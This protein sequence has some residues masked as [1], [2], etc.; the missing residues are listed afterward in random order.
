[1]IY[2][3]L[4]LFGCV[5]CGIILWS[6]NKSKSDEN[7]L[8]Q[9]LP[10][11]ETGIEFT[12]V[13]P[14]ND[15]INLFNYHYLF[16][17]NGVGIGDINNDGLNDVFFSANTG[18][19]KLYLN[20]GDFK[21]EDITEKAGVTTKQWMTGVSM[22]DVNNDGYI[23][24]YVC[25]SGPSKNK[26]DKRNKLFINNKNSTFTE[27]ASKW[28]VDDAGNASCASFFDF[29]N[30]GDLDMYLGNHAEKYFSD[31]NIPFTKQLKM[32]EHSQQHFYRNDGQF[33]TDITES[34]G[35]LAMGYCLSATPSDFNNDGLIDIYVCNDYHI[36]DYYYINNGDGTF[37]DK[38]YSSFKHTSNNSMGSDA[39]DVNNDGFTDLITLDM[40]PESPERFMTLL[41]PRDYDFIN[42]SNRNNYGNQY[43]KNV[44]NINVGNGMFSDQS[45]L[46]GVAR[47]DWSWSPLFCDFN[48]D[49]YQDLFVTN[50]Y[51][52]DVTNLDFVLFKNRREQQNG[53]KVTHKDV[54]DRL[55][56]EKLTN[57]LYINQQGNG[58]SNKSESFGTPEKTLSTGSAYGD[59]DG[60]GQ[61]DLIVCNQG[62][63]ALVYKNVNKSGNFINIKFTSKTNKT[64]IGTKV[65]VEQEAVKRMF[66]LSNNRGYLSSS[67]PIIHIGFGENKDNIKLS[68]VTL[69]G[70]TKELK[71]FEFNRTISI[72]IDEIAGANGKSVIAGLNSKESF[73]E[74]VESLKFKHSEQETPDFKREPLLP[75][76][77]TMLGPGMTT[78]DVNGDGLL[79][80]FMANASG[81]TGSK[82]MLQQN[83]GAFVDAKTQPWTNIKTDVTGCLLF[84]ADGDGDLDLYVATGGSE[85]SW[86]NANYTH[87]LFKNDGKGNFIDN[88]QNLPKVTGSSSSVAAGD[89][90]NDGDLDLFVSGR[91]LPGLYPFIEI[92]S[93]LLRNEE[94][95]FV[96]ATEKD[97]PD[98]FM[99]GM[100][101][102]S[103]FTDY[104]NDGY[105][106]LMLVGEYTPIVFMKN[107]KGK[108]VN[109]TNEV[110]T[111]NYSGW[112]NSIAPIDIDND[113]DLDY[114]ISNKG[115]NSFVRAS[116][117]EPLN[118]YWSD[119]DGNGRHDF[120]F[121]YSKNEKEY[122]LY[123]MDEMVVAFPSFLSKKF[124]TYTAFGGKTMTE[125]FGEPNLSQNKMFANEFSHLLLT[126][127]GNGFAVSKLPFE[128]NIGPITGMMTID[129]NGDGFDD[130]VG[131]GN[132][133]YSRVTHG[134]DDALNGFVLLNNNGKLSF[135]NGPHVG[136]NVPGDGRAIVSL[137]VN[138]SI[139]I[140]ASQ[141]N[142]S[143]KTFKLK[144]NTTFIKAPKGAVKSILT[145]T[146]GKTK[147]CYIGYGGG[148]LS[149]RYPGVYLNKS[150]KSVQFYNSKGQ[151]LK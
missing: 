36:P 81:S 149:G 27:S 65:I 9:A 20:K 45:Y 106:D 109:A 5:F 38:C 91:L 19:S 42:V 146:N 67:E 44:L 30:D 102:E 49:A 7:A 26:E 32:D 68:I 103:I 116:Q 96:D 110:G 84:D 10:S 145:L 86:P 3:R 55:P 111:L 95:K 28:K 136:F 4:K 139:Q 114:V 31:I 100:I 93:Y 69:N 17:G 126:N 135:K 128:A 39:S 57:Y 88:T 74:E 66:E 54:L 113:G 131:T 6:C 82:L 89:Y 108:F 138:N 1:M 52:R 121:G 130:I 18:T 85:F 50:G 77:F 29:D 64:T 132:N 11:S 122:P 15:S 72:D 33:F 12:N 141:N 47:T 144:N 83:N 76:R 71:D 104:N 87:R 59:L 98:L 150:V 133:R 48:N 41:G 92:R 140:V 101:C 134:P 60:D 99:P 21:F 35:M 75:H 129:V 105:Q 147:Q 16:N 80:V 73:F 58:F 53:G 22:V 14:E 46:Y 90:D 107:V 123:Q 8:F 61:I 25:A 24:I 120:F 115:S 94:G 142:A 37:T 127:N 125:I 112:Y 63:P 137:P 151:V 78:G 79:D 118:I 43:M 119:V 62:E 23:D 56:F 124:T 13:V 2:R 148:Y 117:S 34:A 40:L 70:K 97:A 51:Y 143:P